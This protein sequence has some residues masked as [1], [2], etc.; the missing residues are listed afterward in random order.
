MRDHLE[1]CQGRA[2][3]A[4]GNSCE[5]V[6]T[7]RAAIYFKISRRLCQA[8]GRTTG[9]AGRSAKWTR[10]AAGRG[11]RLKMA[12]TYARKHGRTSGQCFSAG[13]RPG[14]TGPGWLDVSWKR[15]GKQSFT[16]QLRRRGQGPRPGRARQGWGSFGSV[17]A[18]FCA[19]E[20]WLWDREGRSERER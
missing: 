10:S 7:A 20:R 12:P 8:G 14:R 6:T 9:P 5:H 17:S 19:P 4:R 11:R 3:A 13:S 16:G 2:R 18:S 1:T 15:S